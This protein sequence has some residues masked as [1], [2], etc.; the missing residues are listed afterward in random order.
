MGEWL[1]ESGRRM[2]PVL[3]QVCLVMWR[4]IGCSQLCCEFPGTW[5][6]VTDGV[7]EAPRAAVSGSG[8]GSPAN[9]ERGAQPGWDPVP[10]PLMPESTSTWLSVKLPCRFSSFNKR[11][12]KLEHTHHPAHKPHYP[13]HT[14]PSTHTTAPSTPPHHSAH[15]PPSTHTTQHPTPPP[16]TP[17]HSV[18]FPP[19]TPQSPS[20]WQ[21]VAEMPQ[22]GACEVSDLSVTLCPGAGKTSVWCLV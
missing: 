3:F 16:S 21:G 8:S 2:P 12:L 9:G 22:A 1:G 11:G 20:P 7:T 5:P 6:H 15:T 14:P 13:V 18:T 4:L 10:C 19:A 17:P